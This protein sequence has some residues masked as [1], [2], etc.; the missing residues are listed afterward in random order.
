MIVPVTGVTQAAGMRVH[1]AEH[2]QAAIGLA[3][4]AAAQGLTAAIEL[5]MA[6]PSIAGGTRREGCQGWP[7]PGAWSG[8]SP[9]TTTAE[10]KAWTNA[11]A[12]VE[13][14]P[15]CRYPSDPCYDRFH[16]SQSGPASQNLKRGSFA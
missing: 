14:R 10:V 15:H 2:G 5:H 13:P 8:R 12:W 16:H 11:R 1:H 4:D 3:D 6:D 7:G 9:T